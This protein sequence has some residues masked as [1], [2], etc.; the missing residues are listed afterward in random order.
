MRSR[1]FCRWRQTQSRWKAKSSG[2]QRNSKPL[3]TVLSM[4]C[5]EAGVADVL[6]TTDDRFVGRAGRGLGSPRVR[7]LNPVAWLREQ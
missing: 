3:V 5:A 4:L 1:C 2:A 7:V 6:L